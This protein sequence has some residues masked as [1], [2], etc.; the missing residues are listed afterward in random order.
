[1]RPN[2]KMRENPET[3]NEKTSYRVI[4]KLAKH[5]IARMIIRKT[6]LSLYTEN[7]NNH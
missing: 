1:M 3:I 7:S 2:L 6:F 4:K 5:H